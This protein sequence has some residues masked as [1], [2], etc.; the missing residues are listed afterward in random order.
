VTI[1]TGNLTPG[2]PGADGLWLKK[3]RG[4]WRLVF[5]HE[6]DSW[7]TQHDPAFDAAEIELAYS[8]GGAPTRSGSPS[9][10]PRREAVASFFTGGRTSGG[11]LQRRS[12]KE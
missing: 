10:R 7:G 1:P 4:G 12:V 5:N 11:R 6:A 9:C 3:A 8:K 2:F